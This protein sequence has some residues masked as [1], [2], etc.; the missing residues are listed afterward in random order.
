MKREDG[1][2]GRVKCMIRNMEVNTGGKAAHPAF[3]HAHRRGHRRLFPRRFCRRLWKGR[4]G[5][6]RTLHAALIRLTPS[7]VEYRVGPLLVSFGRTLDSRYITPVS[8]L[9]SGLRV[10][11]RSV[12]T[13]FGL[14]HLAIN[15]KQGRAPG[16]TD[17]Q[18]DSEAAGC[19]DFLSYVQIGQVCCDY[20]QGRHSAK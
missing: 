1:E 18:W 8:R 9:C 7:S 2:I 15:R 16:P 3:C 6:T 20:G 17:R 4:G 14:D 10:R 12:W 19:R 13:V 11:V 5:I